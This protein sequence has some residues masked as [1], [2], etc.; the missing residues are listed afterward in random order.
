MP[1]RT[2][3]VTTTAA[4]TTLPDKD[5]RLGTIFRSI[6]EAE[7]AMGYLG[8]RLSLP[9]MTASWLG[10]SNAASTI[11]AN[12]HTKKPPQNQT[13]KPNTAFAAAVSADSAARYQNV[14]LF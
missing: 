1:P 12:T 14:P 8:L 2:T 6:R 3:Q 7:V 10:S 5:R 11:P 9:A 4:S 13:T